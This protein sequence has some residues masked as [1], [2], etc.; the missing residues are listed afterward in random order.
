MLGVPGLV[1]RQEEL[2]PNYVAEYLD[3]QMPNNVQDQFES[4]FV[5]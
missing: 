1:D 4:A 5:P 2:D 3:H